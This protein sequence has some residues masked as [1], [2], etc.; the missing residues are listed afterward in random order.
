MLI[1]QLALPNLLALGSRGVWP[2]LLVLSAI[3]IAL[4]GPDIHNNLLQGWFLGFFHDLT[5]MAPF[6]IYTLAI[7]LC[8][9]LI[10]GIRHWLY[11]QNILIFMFIAFVL[12]C[13]I[14]LSVL[15]TMLLRGELVQGHFAPVFATILLCATYNAALVPWLAPLVKQPKWKLL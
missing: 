1:M 7:S 14:E 9:L 2:D 15:L 6:G 5:S 4:R 12:S 8:V 3:V 13:L 10:S 11:L